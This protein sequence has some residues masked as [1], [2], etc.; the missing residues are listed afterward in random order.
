MSAVTL[1]QQTSAST[2]PPPKKQK[3]Y[4]AKSTNHSHDTCCT[5]CPPAHYNERWCSPTWD[6]WQWVSLPGPDLWP[7]AWWSM[8]SPTLYKL[9][10]LH[11]PQQ[12]Q[13]Y[14]PTLLRWL[15]QLPFHTQQCQY[16]WNLKLCP[17]QIQS[18]TLRILTLRPTCQHNSTQKYLMIGPFPHQRM[19]SPMVTSSREL[20]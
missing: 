9:Y 2:A 5:Y 7:P 6:K 8:A 16:Q 18:L 19:L 10:T 17:L 4:Q 14:R 12:H 11:R 3:A 13:R 20:L 1:S 15:Y